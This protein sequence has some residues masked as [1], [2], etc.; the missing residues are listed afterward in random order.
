MVDPIISERIHDAESE[1]NENM[2]HWLHAFLND[3]CSKE[4]LERRFL[5][6]YK[7]GKPITPF[8]EA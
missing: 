2:V 8:W 1:T 4:E 3:D 7:D 6:T 5:E